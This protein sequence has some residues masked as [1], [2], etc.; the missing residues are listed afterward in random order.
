[1][2]GGLSQPNNRFNYDLL[3]DFILNFVY[4][5]DEGIDGTEPNTVSIRREIPVRD[6]NDNAPTFIGRPYA[7][8]L[9]E[10]TPVGSVVEVSPNII[11]TDKDEGRNAEVTLTCFAER[12][13]DVCDTFAVATDKIGDGNFTAIITLLKPLDYETRPS[14]ILTLMAKDGADKNQ[15]TAYATISITIVDVQDQSPIFINAPYSATIE[16][17]MPA[18]SSVLVVTAMDGDTGNPRPIALEIENEKNGHF[19]LESNGKAGQAVIYT[20]DIPIDREDPEILQNGG[21]YTF[22]VR[23]TELIDDDE[24]GDSSVTQVTIVVTDVDDHMP[25]FNEPHFDVYVPENLERDTPLPGL[26][27]FVIDKDM[28]DNS[29]YNLSLRSVE[30][31]EN[32]FEV[33]PS[34]GQ[35]RTPVV[36]KVLDPS[37]LDY[38]IEDAALRTFKFDLV[39]SVKGM[40]LSMTRITAYLQ[41]IYCL[42]EPSR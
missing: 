34:A 24:L 5:L 25:E 38:D 21:V 42:P 36:V 1:M 35:G 13:E 6:Y 23:A 14:Y 39:A 18:D 30:N 3:I 29:Q 15:L 20:T 32:V 26:S 12:D 17:N 31:A 41:V 37:K 9:S 11:V 7:T 27:V 16:E 28:G 33:S 10:S 19:K 2:D 4:I 8:S 22:N 40:D